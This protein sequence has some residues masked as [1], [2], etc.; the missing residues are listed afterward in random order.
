MH[1]QRTL[2]FDHPEPFPAD[3]GTDQA[4]QMIDEANELCEHFRRLKA[5]RRTNYGA[6]KIEKEKGRTTGSSPAE[7]PV[8]RYWEPPTAL[9][10][11]RLDNDSAGD[12]PAMAR[13]GTG[14]PVDC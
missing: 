2:P 11:L 13:P 6:H 9:L 7:P 10:P 14:P 12:Q 5:E 4:R 8:K 1:A 3:T